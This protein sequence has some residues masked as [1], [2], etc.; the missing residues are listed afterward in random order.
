MVI[1]NSL[2]RAGILH[3]LKLL[4]ILAVDSDVVDVRPTPPAL[5]LLVDHVKY[6]ALLPILVDW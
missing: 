4:P 3:V 1:L 5:I 6:G 2:S